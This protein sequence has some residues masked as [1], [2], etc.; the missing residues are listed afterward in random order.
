[1]GCRP[2]ATCDS[3]GGELTYVDARTDSY[4]AVGIGVHIILY[5]RRLD[6]PAPRR[7]A[8][9]HRHTADSGS[10]RSMRKPSLLQRI[11]P[12]VAI[13]ACLATAPMVAQERATVCSR[14]AAPATGGGGPRLQSPYG[15]YQPTIV[16]PRSAVRAAAAAATDKTVLTISTFGLVLL[17]VLLILFI[18]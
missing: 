6:P 15:T 1:M 16:Q 4:S 13:L 10:S 9:G 2:A 18:A 12:A 17:I 14:T 5:V 11:I 3:L 8:G 7:R